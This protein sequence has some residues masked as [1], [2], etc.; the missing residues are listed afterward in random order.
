MAQALSNAGHA[1]Q[2]ADVDTATL[3]GYTVTVGLGLAVHAAAGASRKKMDA[4]GVALVGLSRA[5]DGQRI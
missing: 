4:I 2:G 1:T 3:A 5:F